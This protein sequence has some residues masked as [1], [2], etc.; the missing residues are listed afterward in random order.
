MSEEDSDCDFSELSHG[1]TQL[2]LRPANR[3][4]ASPARGIRAPAKSVLP[5]AD[6]SSP[7]VHLASV[8]NENYH[9]RLELTQ[10]SQELEALRRQM[11]GPEK[12]KQTL[13]AAEELLS[14]KNMRAQRAWEPAG[15]PTRPHQSTLSECE[16]VTHFSGSPYKGERVVSQQDAASQ[17]S[18]S[19]S[20]VHRNHNF[21]RNFVVPFLQRNIDAFRH[22]DMFCEEATRLAQ[23]LEEFKVHGSKSKEL[24][25]QLM[26]EI[27]DGLNHLQQQ[28]VAILNRELQAKK[29]SS[30]LEFLFTVFL[31]PEQYG[32]VRQAHVDKLRQELYDIMLQL[33]DY[34]GRRPISQ[35]VSTSRKPTPSGSPV[36]QIPRS[37]KPPKLPPQ[38]PRNMMHRLRKQ[39]CGLAGAPSGVFEGPGSTEF[40]PSKKVQA[41]NHL[42]HLNNTYTSERSRLKQNRDALEFIPIG[43]NEVMLSKKTPDRRP[44]SRPKL[45][46]SIHMTPLTRCANNE[47]EMETDSLQVFITEFFKDTQSQDD[48]TTTVVS[49]F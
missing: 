7:R 34:D 28:C 20:R 47:E 9:L 41:P 43:Y 16:I 5:N 32:L 48:S 29:V 44:R 17:A 8:R 12:R 15:S 39:P 49:N 46:E 2:S 23:K 14:L 6:S 26:V 45:Q 35:E 13:I 21:F 30:Q 38:V 33:W 40:S 11:Q 37:G 1:L 3:S 31:D 42:N 18:T 27:L 4:A 25:V 36:K 19:N 22:S 10:K 24:K